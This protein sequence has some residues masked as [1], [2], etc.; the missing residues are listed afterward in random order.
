[1]NIVPWKALEKHFKKCNS[2]FIPCMKKKVI[3]VLR[4]PSSLFI[5]LINMPVIEAMSPL[6]EL[7]VTLNDRA[8]GAPLPTLNMVKCLENYLFK[9]FAHVI[10]CF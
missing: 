1:M 5:N 2:R 8:H 6:L 3:E 9:E 4:F 7:M 10:G